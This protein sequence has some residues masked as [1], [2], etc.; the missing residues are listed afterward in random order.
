MNIIA[1]HAHVFQPKIKKEGTIK[2]LKELMDECSIAKAVRF[3]PFDR[4]FV[5]NRDNPNRWLY[6]QIKNEDDLLGFGTIDFSKD[7]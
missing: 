6:E 3:A 7:N 4:H 5:S 1:N 2:S